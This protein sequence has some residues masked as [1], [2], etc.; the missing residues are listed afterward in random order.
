MRGAAWFKIDTPV[1]SYVQ[2]GDI[3]L[4]AKSGQ[5]IINAC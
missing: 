5:S 3:Q 2:V 1:G 4:D